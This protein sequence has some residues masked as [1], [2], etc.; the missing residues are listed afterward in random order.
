LP[1]KHTHADDHENSY[2]GKEEAIASRMG[3]CMII[4][5]GKQ[6]GHQHRA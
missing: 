2:L 1:D 3:I 4:D 6:T 5:V